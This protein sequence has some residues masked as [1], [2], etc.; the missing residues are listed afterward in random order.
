MRKLRR[1]RGALKI[2]NRTTFDSIFTSFEQI[3]QDLLRVQNAILQNR[4]SP[5]LLDEE[6]DCHARLNGALARQLEYMW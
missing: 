3:M 5:T 4:G 2:W 6:V 1:L